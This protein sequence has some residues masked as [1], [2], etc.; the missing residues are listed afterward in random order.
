MRKIMSKIPRGWELA[1]KISR[2]KVILTTVGVPFTT[3]TVL[4]S[5]IILRHYVQ[6][7]EP[8]K[9]EVHAQCGAFDRGQGFLP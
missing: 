4:G 3:F 5:H 7:P 6:T 1:Y 8:I 9:I 2:S